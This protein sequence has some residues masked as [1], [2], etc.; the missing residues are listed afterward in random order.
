MQ[1][2]ATLH[3]EVNG[4]I[5]AQEEA[6]FNPKQAELAYEIVYAMCEPFNK[7]RHRKNASETLKSLKRLEHQ[8]SDSPV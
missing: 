1:L 2:K 8:K 3:I 7:Y 4:E 6:L 5:F